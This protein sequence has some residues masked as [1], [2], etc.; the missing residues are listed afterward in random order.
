MLNFERSFCIIATTSSAL[1][2][3]SAL[4]SR[5]NWAWGTFLRTISLIVFQAE[6][7]LLSIAAVEENRS[8]L[9]IHIGFSRAIRA[10]TVF[11]FSPF[12]VH[13]PSW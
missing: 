9:E 3:S 5:S 7:S 11:A 6:I 8:R 13:I 2:Y 1:L 10:P 4:S 12:T